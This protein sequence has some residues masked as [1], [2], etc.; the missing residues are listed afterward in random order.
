M[1]AIFINN[2]NTALSA[3]EA[4]AK[5][6]KDNLIP[7]FV[8]DIDL[9]NK[10]AVAALGADQ[11]ALGKQTAKMITKLIKNEAKVNETPVEMPEK[12]KLELNIPVANHLDL[13]FKQD[14]V[15]QTARLGN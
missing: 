2:D 15:P 1:D 12:V 9:V 4:V 10:G 5:V 7:V 6:G 13:E 14:L 3:F 8:S 11:F